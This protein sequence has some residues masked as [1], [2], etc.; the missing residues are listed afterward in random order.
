[1]FI[2]ELEKKDDE[3]YYEDAYEETPQSFSNIQD[4]GSNASPKTLRFSESVRSPASTHSVKPKPAGDFYGGVKDESIAIEIQRIFDENEI[5]DLCELL[6]KRNCINNM[7]LVL[8]YIFHL[9]QTSGILIT[10]I[11]SGYGDTTLI[12]LGVSLNAVASLIHII[13][14]T[15][16]SMLKKMMNDIKKIKSGN[17]VDET[18]IF[19][20]GEESVY[21]KN[22]SK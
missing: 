17:Y 15:N 12:W 18:P 5:N 10:T 13:E 4:N 9:I 3:L 16:N 2:R 1:M 8:V 14:K 7:N 11:A 6:R 19:D 20:S 21:T 22:T